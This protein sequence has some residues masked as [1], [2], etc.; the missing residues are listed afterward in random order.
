MWRSQHYADALLLA[1]GQRMTFFAGKSAGSSPITF[2]TWLPFPVVSD[3]T[4]PVTI[5]RFT[6]S[7]DNQFHGSICHC[8]QGVFRWDLPH[9]DAGFK[10]PFVG[11]L[12]VRADAQNYE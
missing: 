3:E 2:G 11:I 10:A 7:F 6:S 12:L 5:S 4:A 1:Q 8:A 9:T